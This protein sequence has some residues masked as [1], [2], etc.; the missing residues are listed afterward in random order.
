M[1]LRN[2]V[3][4]GEPPKSGPQISANPDSSNP[5]QMASTAG[6]GADENEII[7]SRAFNPELDDARLDDQLTLGNN[8]QFG[9][10]VRALSHGPKAQPNSSKDGMKKTIIRSGVKRPPLPKLAMPIGS[11]KLSKNPKRPASHSQNPTE[12]SGLLISG[13]NHYLWVDPQKSEWKC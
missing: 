11:K 10:A 2:T 1:Y 8:N 4:D 6:G 7:R 13:Q 3:Q 5:D 9:R 12:R